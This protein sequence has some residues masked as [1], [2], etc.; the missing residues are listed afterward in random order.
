MIV[1]GIIVKDGKLLV[2][3]LGGLKFKGYLVG[4]IGV[5]MYVM[6]VM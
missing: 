4:V 2:N 3:F 6:V 5:L 1:E